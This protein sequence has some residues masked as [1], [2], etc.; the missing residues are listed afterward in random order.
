MT[1]REA[2]SLRDHLERLLADQRSYFERLLAEHEAHHNRDREANERALDEARVRMEQRLGALN[3]LRQ[4]VTEDRGQLVQRST[5]EARM[6]AADKDR[7]VIRDD[8]ASMRTEVSN[9]RGRQAAYAAMVGVA[10][11]LVPVLIQLFLGR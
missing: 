8:L 2:V 3:E 7:G 1:S 6:E 10:I 5:F 9:M 4:E 11:I